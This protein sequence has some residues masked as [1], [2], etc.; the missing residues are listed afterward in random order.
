VTVLEPFPEE[1]DEP[2]RFANLGTSTSSTSSSHSG[3]GQSNGIAVK[4]RNQ[5]DKA[6][7]ALP[8]ESYSARRLAMDDIELAVLV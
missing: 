4:L 5:R 3:P 2:F 1:P 7:D 8:N 6:V